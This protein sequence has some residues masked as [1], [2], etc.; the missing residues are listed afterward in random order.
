MIR[1]D[2]ASVAVTVAVML[3][4]LMTLVG[5]VIQLGSARII[6][7]R[8]ASAADLATLAAVDDQDDTQLVAS[9][10]LALPPDAA[11]I[12]RAY[13]A[14]NLEAIAR[15]MAVLPRDAA[16][17]A[18]VAVFDRMP[19]MDPLTG[20]RYERPTVRLAATVPVRTLALGPFLPAVI[21]ISV[22]TA[23]SSR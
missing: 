13:F 3:P 11:A 8:V 19:A 18:D 5:G 2:R 17:Q 4:L 15:Q 1:D 16:A 23:S 6:A 21:D 10:A 7:A 22:R 9:G 12:A 20:W 14:A